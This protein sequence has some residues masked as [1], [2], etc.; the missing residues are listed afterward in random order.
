[1]KFLIEF[2]GWG[3]GEEIWSNDLGA[4]MKIVRIFKK[5][6]PASKVYSL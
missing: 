4:S 1:M 2:Y 3:G 5:K 6:D